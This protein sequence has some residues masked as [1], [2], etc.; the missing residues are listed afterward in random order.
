M[1]KAVTSENEESQVDPDRIEAELIELARQTGQAVEDFV[2]ERPH[3]ALAIATGIGF[4][5]GG[6]LTPRRLLR[7]GFLLAGPALTRGLAD[8]VA[9][10]VEQA[11]TSERPPG[12]RSESK[13]GGVPS[14]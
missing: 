14:A 8:R 4:V 12:A 9:A 1:Q 13:H 5:I 10:S 7:W 3:V 6:G 2:V 11:L